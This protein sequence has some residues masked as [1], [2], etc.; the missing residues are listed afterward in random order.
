VYTVQCTAVYRRTRAPVPA[1][2]QPPEPEYDG[3][4]VLLHHLPPGR[5]PGGTLKQTQSEKGRVANT[6]RSEAAVRRREQAV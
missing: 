6:S 1:E 3:A 4:L 5:G 2:R